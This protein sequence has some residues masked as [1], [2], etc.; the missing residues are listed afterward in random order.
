MNKKVYVFGSVVFA[1]ALALAFAVNQF[2][3]KTAFYR[4]ANLSVLKESSSDDAMA[5]LNDDDDQNFE[6]D[7]QSD[8]DDSMAWLTDSG[9]ELDDDDDA[10]E[11]EDSM[12]WMLDDV[13]TVADEFDFIAEEPSSIDIEQDPIP[14]KTGMLDFLSGSIADTDLPEIDDIL[15]EDVF[16]DTATD[17][18]RAL[19]G[20]DPLPEEDEANMFADDFAPLDTSDDIDAL[21]W[22]TDDEVSANDDFDWNFDDDT[23]EEALDWTIEPTAQ[24]DDMIFDDFDDNQEDDA[25]AADA[26][27]LSEL[28]D[29]DSDDDFGFDD[30]I[31]DD[32][33]PAEA[34]W[35]SELGDDDEDDFGFDEP[36]AEEQLAETE[37]LATSTMKKLVV[38]L[39]KTMN[40][41]LIRIGQVMMMLLMT[42]HLTMTMMM[43]MNLQTLKMHLLQKLNAVCSS[44]PLLQ[45]SIWLA[46]GNGKGK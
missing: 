30:S 9:I 42:S 43:M 25:Q 4:Q 27:W 23:Q 21:D 35:L 8:D 26:D 38:T 11:D 16:D 39:A 10:S 13:D 1:G 14:G 34:D 24:A 44:R 12:P 7:T 5:W 17:W 3:P 40:N 36:T 46:L 45:I 15:E 31:A 28:G 41:L 2:L 18:L 6:D 32:A 29:D 22:G 20:K 33:Q 19:D 37:W